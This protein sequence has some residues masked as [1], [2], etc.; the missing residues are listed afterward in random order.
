M[1]NILVMKDHQRT[2]DAESLPFQQPQNYIIIDS[3][4]GEDW[5][6]L[7]F[8]YNKLKTILRNTS[9]S[10]WRGEDDKVTVKFLTCLKVT[11]LLL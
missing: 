1:F 4:N 5:E 8:I 11:V 3:R 2:L 10:L 7:L 6:D 9:D